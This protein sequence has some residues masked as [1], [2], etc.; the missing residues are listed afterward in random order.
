MQ[1]IMSHVSTT[2]QSVNAAVD[3]GKAKDQE[4][5]GNSCKPN[6]EEPSDEQEQC[7]QE[8][9]TQKEHDSNEDDMGNE[10]AQNSP[11]PSVKEDN[12]ENVEE[13]ISAADTTDQREEGDDEA[14]GMIADI[15]ELA[16]DERAE[17]KCELSNGCSGVQEVHQE[18]MNGSSSPVLRNRRKRRPKKDD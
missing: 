4:E 12:S 17:D 6:T 15:K 1:E 14:V 13:V 8:N 16:A 11:E 2:M 5:C 7:S 9:L 3:V 18:E 10:E